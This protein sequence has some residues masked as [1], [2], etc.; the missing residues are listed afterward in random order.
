MRQIN[1]ILDRTHVPHPKGA[2]FFEEETLA[3]LSFL[4]VIFFLSAGSA[5]GFCSPRKKTFRVGENPKGLV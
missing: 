1:M 4:A 2:K 3:P 5:R